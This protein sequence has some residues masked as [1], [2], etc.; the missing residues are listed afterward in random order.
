MSIGF[1]IL[2][3]F[4]AALQVLL[5]LSGFLAVAVILIFTAIRTAAHPR[6]DQ[7][8]RNTAHRIFA[9]DGKRMLFWGR[10]ISP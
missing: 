1:S 6:A 4:A 9:A 7:H 5:A 8:H 2:R 3:R 10:A